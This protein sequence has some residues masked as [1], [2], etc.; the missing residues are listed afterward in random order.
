MLDDLA[1]RYKTISINDDN[2]AYNHEFI[3]EFRTIEEEVTYIASE[4]CKLFNNGVLFNQIKLCGA[5]GEYQS[6]IKRI[7]KWYIFL[8]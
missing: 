5:T 7:F 2:I 1:N 8:L 6:I 3:Y 4:I